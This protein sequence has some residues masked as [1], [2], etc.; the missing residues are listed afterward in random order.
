M[1]KKNF[2]LLITLFFFL[3][4]HAQ[5]NTQYVLISFDGSKTLSMWKKVLDVGRKNNARFTFFVS[6]VYFLTD[7]NSDLYRAPSGRI[8]RSFIGFGGEKEHVE[9][10][11]L[12]VKQAMTE[13]HEISSHANGHFQGGLVKW[14][15]KT[16]GE[17][18]SFDQWVHELTSFNHFVWDSHTI[19]NIDFNTRWMTDWKNLMS[20]QMHGFRAPNL[21]TNNNMFTALSQTYFPNGFTHNYSYDSSSAK[22]YSHF[23]KTKGGL[24][25]LP[26]GLVTVH[27]TDKETIAMDYNFY[28][29]DSGASFDKNS[30]NTNLY[31]ERYY[32]SL[33]GYFNKSVKKN[34]TPVI[35]GNHFSTWNRGAYFKGL[36]RFIKDVC[37]QRNVRCIPMA[38]YV[39]IATNAPPR[40]NDHQP[41]PDKDETIDSDDDTDDFYVPEDGVPVDISFLE[42]IQKKCKEEKCPNLELGSSIF[43]VSNSPLVN[44][45]NRQ[46]LSCDHTAHNEEVDVQYLE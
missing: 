40:M 36:V 2:L 30:A 34:N 13:R 18:W 12:Y 16:E 46:H 29:N 25:D 27:G 21:S 5:Q 44:K 26:L 8:G 15:G 7:E 20:M 35:I 42:G 32:K 3:S 23:Q 37:P 22:H 39:Q 14:L 11:L 4:S 45:N 28:V 38:E 19:N 31:E 24:W 43:S 1:Y 33:K 10:R 41:S 17:N 6:G 9:Q